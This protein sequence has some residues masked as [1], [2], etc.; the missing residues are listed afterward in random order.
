MLHAC[1]IIARNYLAD[2]RVLTDS[3]FAHHPGGTF[4]VLIIDDEAR[5][6]APEEPRIEWLRLS[7]LGIPRTE[8]HRLAGIYDVTELATAVS[9]RLLLRLL[10]EGRDSV[11]YLDPDILICHSLAEVGSLAGRHDIVLTP[12]TLE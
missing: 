10:D 8:I 9:P 7:D 6:L 1:T 4:T 12:H 11:V 5:E 3:F 2:A